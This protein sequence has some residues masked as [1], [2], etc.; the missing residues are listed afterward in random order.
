MRGLDDYLTRERDDSFDDREDVCPDCGWREC[1]CRINTRGYSMKTVSFD[2]ACP[3]LLCVTQEPHEH[4]VCETCNAMN[5]GN[6]SCDDCR[7]WRPA[8]E[9]QVIQP[10]LRE[11]RKEI[12]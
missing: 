4:P 3:F 1:L 2:G 12:R 7:R 10:A 5:F 8:Y 9:K 6:L 11:L